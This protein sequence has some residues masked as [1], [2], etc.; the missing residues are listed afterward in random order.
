MALVTKLDQL[1]EKPLTVTLNDA[2]RTKIREQLEGLETSENL[3]EEDAKKRLEAILKELEGD[4][5][6]LTRAG[7]RWPGERPPNLGFGGAQGEN[8]NPFREEANGKPLKAL[9]ERLKPN[10]T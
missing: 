1:T 8:V 10:K 9:N 3:T 7:Y 4:R 5:E 2:Q 6:T